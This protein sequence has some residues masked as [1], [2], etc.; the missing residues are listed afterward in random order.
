M[1]VGAR[2]INGVGVAAY[3]PLPRTTGTGPAIVAGTAPGYAREILAARRALS[4]APVLGVNRFGTEH[5]AGCELWVSVHPETY[6][7]K[8]GSAAWPRTCSDRPAPGV[9]LVWPIATGGGSSAL[10]AV[11]IAL[12]M[13]HGPVVCSGVHLDGDYASYRARWEE[14][15]A[16][17][18]G[19][20]FSFSP[21]GTW[22]RDYFGS[23]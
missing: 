21:R 2:M 18:R 20:V 6:F 1:A 3:A 17:L 15:A 22:L 10:L 14:L 8:R 5:G 7:R 4:S 16:C 9:D 12:V 11:L 13:G 19:R 23:L